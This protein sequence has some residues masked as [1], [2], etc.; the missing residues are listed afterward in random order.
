[1]AKK[2]DIRATRKVD[3]GSFEGKPVVGARIIV[4]NTGDGLSNAQA[5]DP[6]VLRQG[7]RVVVAFECDIA[8]I[9]HDPFVKDELDGD[10]VRV[11]IAHAESAVILGD[12]A[13]LSVVKK[14][15]DEQAKRI[16]VAVEEAQGISRL[17]GVDDP[18]PAEKVTPAKSSRS[19]KA[20]KK[21]SPAKRSRRAT[22]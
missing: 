22:H 1:M 17:P 15:L 4:R 9:R 21:K 11:H 6:V 16:E 3:L 12:G 19:K 20:A 8:E 2:V 7:D 13:G 14:A 18:A 5:V 10:Q